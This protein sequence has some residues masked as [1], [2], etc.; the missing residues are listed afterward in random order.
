MSRHKTLLLALV[1]LS[2]AALF[3]LPREAV[4]QTTVVTWEAA[5]QYTDGDPLPYGKV[6]TAVN[7][8]DLG[9]PPVGPVVAGKARINLPGE[10]QS[11]QFDVPFGTCACFELVTWIYGDPAERYISA[12]VYT[13]TCKETS[14]GCH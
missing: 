12:P 3:M 2:A 11:A 4:A 5:T 13:E 10:A 6:W 1:M 8:Y 7:Q 14:G 9:C